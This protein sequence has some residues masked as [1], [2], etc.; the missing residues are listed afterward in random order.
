MRCCGFNYT[1]RESIRKQATHGRNT[2]SPRITSRGWEQKCAHLAKSNP[3]AKPCVSVEG[4]EKDIIHGSLLVI[5]PVEDG[6]G[7]VKRIQTL[8]ISQNYVSPLSRRKVKVKEPNLLYRFT[9]PSTAAPHIWRPLVSD[10]ETRRSRPMPH[11]ILCCIFK[12]QCDVK[13]DFDK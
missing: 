8:F 12:F 5:S 13:V 6:G 9:R 1:S 11:G 2:K 4:E 7:P 10:T 3:S